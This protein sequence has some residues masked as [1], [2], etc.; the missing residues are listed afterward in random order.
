MVIK[1]IS[2]LGKY[3]FLKVSYTKVKI[4]NMKILSDR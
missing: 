1:N 3:I 2:S 4:L